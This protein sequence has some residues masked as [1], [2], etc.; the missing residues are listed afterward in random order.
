MIPHAATTFDSSQQTLRGSEPVTT[1]Q[2]LEHIPNI[3]SEVRIESDPNAPTETSL[4]TESWQRKSLLSFGK[5]T[6]PMLS[7][8]IG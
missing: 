2:A 6:K 7:Q 8:R 1:T 5:T 4:V 3:E